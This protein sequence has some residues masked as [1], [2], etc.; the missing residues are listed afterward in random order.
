MSG[1]PGIP[2]PDDLVLV[3]HVTGAY[4]LAGWVKLKPYSDDAGALL[5]A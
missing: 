2:V 5:H 4:G 1:A 3:A